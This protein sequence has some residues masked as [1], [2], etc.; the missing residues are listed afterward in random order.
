MLLL[1][2]LVW[3]IFNG[4]I[5]AEIVIFGAVIALLVFAF[6]CKFMDYS[7]RKEILLVKKSGYFIWYVITLVVEIVRA[8]LAVIHLILSQKEIV[9]PVMVT[10]TTHLKSKIAR[11]IL[12]NSITL[13]PGTITVSL[14]GDKLVVHCLDKSLAEGMED[15]VFVKMLEKLE[16]T[17]E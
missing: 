8:N 15:S 16:R 12:A 3:I 4:A 6:I 1:F 14:R 9:E 13:T 2:F 17:G 10:F 11:V 5:T 7:I